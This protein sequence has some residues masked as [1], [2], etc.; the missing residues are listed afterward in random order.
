M[1]FLNAAYV[2]GLKERKA[3]PAKEEVSV[4]NAFVGILYNGLKKRENEA[5]ASVDSAVVNVA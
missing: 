5:D 3:E 1:A 4:D 2:V